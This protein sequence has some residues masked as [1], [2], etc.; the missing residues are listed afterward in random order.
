MDSRGR[1]FFQRL[2][3]LRLL[4]RSG[5]LLENVSREVFTHPEI[6]RCGI[7]TTLVVNA[8][9]IVNVISAG[10]VH[11][12][13][14]DSSFN[15]SPEDS[16]IEAAACSSILNECLLIVMFHRRPANATY[17]ESHYGG[18]NGSRRKDRGQQRLRFTVKKI[19][20]VAVSRNHYEGVGQSG[21]R[22]KSA[23]PFRSY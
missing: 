12:V 19:V 20:D 11:W 7:N 5:R 9:I 16:R 21:T 23:L 14:A 15:L 3:A 13:S 18:L 17:D 6:V 2:P 10:R 4:L 22:N 1:A 8:S